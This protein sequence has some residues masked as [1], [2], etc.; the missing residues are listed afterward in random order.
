[1]ET[2]VGIFR[3]REDAV[4]AARGLQSLGFEARNVLILYPDHGQSDVEAVPSED[5]EQPGNG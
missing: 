4:R 5:A 3:M 1:M 2:I